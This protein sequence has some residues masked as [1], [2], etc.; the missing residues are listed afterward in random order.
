VTRVRSAGPITVTEG[1]EREIPLTGDTCPQ[2]AN[3]FKQ[4]VYEGDVVNN[5]CSGEVVLARADHEVRFDLIQTGPFGFKRAVAEYLYEPG[6]E[7]THTITASVRVSSC[8]DFENRPHEIVINSIKVD[9][10][11]FR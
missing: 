2:G 7:K 6:Q 8:A 1:E 10:I 11:G 5:L 9:V 4:V 3:E